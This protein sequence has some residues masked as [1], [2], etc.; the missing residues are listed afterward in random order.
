MRGTMADDNI[1]N[2]KNHS[3]ESMKPEEQSTRHKLKAYL[4]RRHGKD[5]R[6]GEDRRR[7]KDRRTGKGIFT[8][9]EKRDGKERRS[10]EDRRSGQERRGTRKL[11]IPFLL[12]LP[13]YP[14]Y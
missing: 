8:K 13:V 9:K 7:G 14:L 4:V 5:R 2:K 11:R 6:R 1:E 12:S 10:G 3:G